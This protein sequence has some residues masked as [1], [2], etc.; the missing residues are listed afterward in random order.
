KLGAAV[1]GVEGNSA[2]NIGVFG[3]GDNWYGVVGNS[4]I[5]I[6]VMGNSISSAGVAGRSRDSYGVYALSKTYRGLIAET[7]GT[8]YA[9]V[10]SGGKGLYASDIHFPNK[11][12]DDSDGKG[13]LI[14]GTL[15]S[16]NTCTAVCGN[17]SLSCRAVSK[18][19][20]NMPTCSDT[21][22]GRY[23]WCGQA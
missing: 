5:G 12:F 1:A 3:R 23:C 16:S 10:I 20:G 6:G 15:L 18:L 19:D 2:N 14:L 8:D 13:L 22:I 7:E 21:S 9:A 11:A 4:T 17:H